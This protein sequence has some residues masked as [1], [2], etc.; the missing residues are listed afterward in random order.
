MIFGH[1]RR[2]K[3]EKGGRAVLDR[4]VRRVSRILG[5]GHKDVHPEN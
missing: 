3:V 1:S 5:S 2:V 4:R